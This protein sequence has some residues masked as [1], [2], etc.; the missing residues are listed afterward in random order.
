MFCLSIHPLV[1]IW[2]VSGFLA[3]VHSA[4]MNLHVES[5]KVLSEFS[6]NSLIVRKERNIDL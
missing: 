6:L 4:A 5:T 3:I 2:A 1:D